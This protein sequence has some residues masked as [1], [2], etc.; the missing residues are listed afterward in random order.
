M[1]TM[2]NFRKFYLIAIKQIAQDTFSN[3]AAYHNFFQFVIELISPSLQHS[4]LLHFMG[5]MG[6]L[7]H[8][9]KNEIEPKICP[10]SCRT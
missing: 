4:N 9:V 3:N 1:M 5:N 8:A 10:N 7:C 6:E 2:T